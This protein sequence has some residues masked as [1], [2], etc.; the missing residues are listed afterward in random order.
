MAAH[1]CVVG[2]GLLSCTAHVRSAAAPASPT[3]PPVYARASLLP[4]KRLVRQ[5]AAA[6]VPGPVP[7]A[8]P[9][10]HA[11]PAPHPFIPFPFKVSPELAG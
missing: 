6:S 2:L 8:C 10:P 9:A 3:P 5:V 1:L 7:H 11:R 4:A